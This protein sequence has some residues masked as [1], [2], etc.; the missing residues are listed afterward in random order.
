M[1][2]FWP[3][4]VVRAGDSSINASDWATTQAARAS[5][6]QGKEGGSHPT[7]VRLVLFSLLALH[8]RLSIFGA[9]FTLPNSAWISRAMGMLIFVATCPSDLARAFWPRARLKR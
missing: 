9:G 8:S 7:S 2:G 3:F 6:L 5:S 1:S 4:A